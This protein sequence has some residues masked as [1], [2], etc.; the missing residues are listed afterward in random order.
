MATLV[1]RRMF[2]VKDGHVTPC[3]V[4]AHDLATGMCEIRVGTCRYRVS[5]YGWHR[6][7]P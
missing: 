1:N 7:R 2:W 3:L 5:A 6:Q 4:V